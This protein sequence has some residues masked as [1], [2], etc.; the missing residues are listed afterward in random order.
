MPD[1]T[2]CT[3]PWPRHPVGGYGRRYGAGADHGE[4]RFLNGVIDPQTAR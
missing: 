1:P 3:R 2:S 4:K